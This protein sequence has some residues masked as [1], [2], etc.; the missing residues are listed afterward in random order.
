MTAGGSATDAATY[1]RDTSKLIR[2]RADDADGGIG[3]NTGHDPG[4]W[5]FGPFD[6]DYSEVSVGLGTGL[7]ERLTTDVMTD[8]VGQH[9][10]SWDP[11]T[12]RAVADL[13]DDIAD[14][15]E[16]RGAD[17]NGPIP[18]DNKVMAI[19]RAYRREVTP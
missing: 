10:A 9:I 7:A 14:M 13:L 12:A 19:A 1:L 11:Y 8:A 5:D 18:Y 3:L 15:W 2:E 6:A 17:G 4:R 16:K